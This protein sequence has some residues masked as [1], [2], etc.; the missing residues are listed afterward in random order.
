MRGRDVGEVEPAGE[1]VA[2]GEDEPGP[3]LGVPLQLAVGQRTVPA[4][5]A[6]SAALRLSGRLNPMSSTWPSPLGGDA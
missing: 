2:V 4:A 1:V 6:K 5:A 3:Q